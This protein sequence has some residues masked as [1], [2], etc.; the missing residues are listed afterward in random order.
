M[1]KM[2]KITKETCKENGVEVIVVNYKKWLNATNM[3]DQLRHS[4]LAAVT[5][6]YPPKYRKKNKNY[7]IVAS[8]S[9]LE[10]S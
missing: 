10:Y 3:K 6:Q 4:N 8:I 9:L 2:V 1:F 5:L 7:K